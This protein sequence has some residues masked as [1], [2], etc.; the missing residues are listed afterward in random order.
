MSVLSPI[1]RLARHIRRARL[2][3]AESDLAW[4]ETVG[5]R[6][7]HR[8]REHVANLREQLE[9]SAQQVSS[10]DIARAASRR[11]REGLIFWRTS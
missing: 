10:D 9:R 2:A 6:E 1:R 3:M 5:Q 8:R 7:L 4:L 11:A